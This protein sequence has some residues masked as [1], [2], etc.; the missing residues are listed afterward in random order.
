ME[1]QDC[2]ATWVL[3]LLEN[4]QLTSLKNVLALDK[5]YQICDIIH[6]PKNQAFNKKEKK[7]HLFTHWTDLNVSVPSFSHNHVPK[8]WLHK[9]LLIIG[10]T[11]NDANFIDLYIKDNSVVLHFKY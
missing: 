7:Q 6:T 1:Y 5:F 3:D 11:Q 9:K 8:K 2:I 4:G 10:S